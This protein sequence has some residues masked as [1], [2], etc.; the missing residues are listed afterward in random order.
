MLTETESD[1]GHID[2]YY[3]KTKIWTCEGPVGME[4]CSIWREY[5]WMVQSKLRLEV[6]C[7]TETRA[8]EYRVGAIG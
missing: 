5:K 2:G 7:S 6:M 1:T 8:C 4:L 3:G